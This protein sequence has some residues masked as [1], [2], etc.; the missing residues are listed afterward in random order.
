MDVIKN[1]LV[2]RTDAKI[3][4]QFCIDKKDPLYRQYRGYRTSM[5]LEATDVYNLYAGTVVMIYGSKDIGFQV[6]VAADVDNLIRYENLKEIDVKKND[7][8]DI[9]TKIGS[10]KR[11]LDISYFTTQV[12]NDHPVRVGN[13]PVMYKDDPMKIIDPSNPAIMPITI[14]YEES[15]LMDTVE[16]YDG[17]IDESAVYELTGNRGEDD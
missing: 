5:R 10:V 12:K 16:E 8:I 4:K 1:C 11:F 6:I 13:F 3:V 14:V 2:T 7:S 17:G 9:G 15:G